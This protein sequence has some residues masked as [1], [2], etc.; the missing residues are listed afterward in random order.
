ML[1][2]NYETLNF[3]KP[4]GYLRKP[5][6]IITKLNSNSAVLSLVQ[7]SPSLFLDYFLLTT[8]KVSDKSLTVL[9]GRY[10]KSFES[11]EYSELV[12]K[13]YLEELKMILG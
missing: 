1:A 4:N 11:L 8:A 6:P 5:Q 9:H 2:D 7:R 13:T 12:H 3:L 10:T